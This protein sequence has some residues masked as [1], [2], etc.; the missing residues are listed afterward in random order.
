MTKWFQGICCTL[1]GT[2][3][4]AIALLQPH[5]SSTAAEIAAATDA[6]PAT[7]ELPRSASGSVND[8]DIVKFIN[9]QIRKGWQEGGIGPSPAATENEWCRRVYLDVIGRLPTVEELDAYLKSGGPDKRL[10]LVSMLTGEALSSNPK[11]QAAAGDR[12]QEYEQGD[13]RADL[14]PRRLDRPLRDATGTHDVVVGGSKDLVEPA[15]AR[16]GTMARVPI[17]RQRTWRWIGR[18]QG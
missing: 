3:A 13:A 12:Q 17:A 11:D 10:K 14:A 4:C 15:H 18:G 2:G 16:I 1:V 6:T 5:A 9:E 7:R 8:Q